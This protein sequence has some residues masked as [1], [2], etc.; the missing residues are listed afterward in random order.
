M[1]KVIPGRMMAEI[2]GDFVVFMIGMRINRWWK[3][4]KWLPVAMSMPKMIKELMTHPENGCLYIQTYLGVVI[5]YWK[6]FEHLE[7]YARATDKAHLPAWNAFNRKVRASSGDIGIWHETYL[8]HAGE[9]ETV[10]SSV[11]PMGLAR[12]GRLVPV[13]KEK[14]AARDR[15][16]RGSAPV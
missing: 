2:D 14:D 12:A 11:P 3:F 4:H 16:R 15:L 5:Q 13:S 7:A 6:S 10:Y 8:V 1:A 9:Y